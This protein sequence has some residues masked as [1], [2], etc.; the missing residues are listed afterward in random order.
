M[1]SKGGDTISQFPEASFLSRTVV[2]DGVTGAGG[3]GG[4]AAQKPSWSFRT[5]TL[6]GELGE[7]HQRFP[8]AMFR[9][10]PI[11]L[12]PFPLPFTFLGL[13]FV[14]DGLS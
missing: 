1:F 6:T 4:T 2:G 14:F 8:P 9:S 7:P 13:P 12:R 11:F 3:S 5:R 10:H